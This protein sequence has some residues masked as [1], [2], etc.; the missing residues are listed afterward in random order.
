[1]ERIQLK[2]AFIHNQ[3]ENNMKLFKLA[4]VF[5]LNLF[6]DINPNQ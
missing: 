6:L 4:N 3:G 1:M 2:L 5:V